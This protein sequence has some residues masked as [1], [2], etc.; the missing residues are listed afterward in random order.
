MLRDQGRLPEVGRPLSQSTERETHSRKGREGSHSQVNGDQVTRVGRG[1]G[2]GA[3]SR[4]QSGSYP[5]GSG[6]PQAVEFSELQT[7][8]VVLHVSLGS[9]LTPKGEDS[10]EDEDTEYFDAMEDST[11]FITVITEAKEDRWVLQ[12]GLAV[13]G[14]SLSQG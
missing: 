7:E 11:S 1:R 14:R 2:A 5:L 4:V 3:R 9:L 8:A 13:P 12:A 6:L 10:E